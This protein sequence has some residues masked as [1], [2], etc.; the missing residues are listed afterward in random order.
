MA[1]ATKL[2]SGN[3]RVQAS[4]KVNGETFKRSFTDTTAKKA[5]KKAEDWQESLKMIGS[6]YSR[7]TVKEAIE[8][9]ISTTERRL[10]PPTVNEYLRIAKNDMQDIID[11]PLYSLTNPIIDSSM[12][13]ALETLSPKTVKNRYGLL[14][15]IL[16]VYHPTFV[17]SATFPEPAPKKKREFSNEYIKSI[18]NAIKGEDFELEV[19]LGILSLRESEICGLKWD[20]VDL[21]KKTIDICRSKLLNKNKEYEI[22]EHNKTNLSTRTVYLPD[23]VCGLL[24]ERQQK[25]ES[26]FIT[27]VPPNRFWKKFNTILKKENIASLKFHG[28]RHIYSSLSSALKIDSEIRML[29]G[30][31]ASEKIMDGSYRHPITEEQ[32]S[33]NSKI[34]NY[35]NQAIEPTKQKTTSKKYRVVKKFFLKKLP[36]KFTRF[37][38]KA[39]K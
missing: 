2:P 7:M 32:L 26:D 18:L 36:R 22:V 3:W 20:V 29:N 35:I 38:K 6:D 5:E 37:S 16:T 14:K 10:S 34:N 12:N 1:K 24:R 30:G 23:Y 17:W 27:E 4:V 8:F 19:Y 33:A 39:I 15:R 13:K 9:Y 11:K 31:W 28:L 21:D 25:S